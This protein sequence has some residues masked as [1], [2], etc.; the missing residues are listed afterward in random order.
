[1]RII[2]NYFLKEFL[3]NFLFSFLIITFF[4]ALGNLMIL[5]DMVI[6]KN[7]NIFSALQIFLYRMPYL[8]IY[9]LPLSFLLGV[10]LCVG[11]ISSDNEI[12]ALKVA[13][14]SFFKILSVFLMVGFIISLFSIVLNDYIIPQAHFAS[15][16]LEGKVGRDNPLAF[17][18]PGSFIEFN[19]YKLFAQDIE[20]NTLKNT[21]IYELKDGSSNVI[22]A[23]KGDFII[24]ED[25]LKIKLQNGF[26]EGPGMKYRIYF[27]NH[28]MHLPVEKQSTKVSKKP[29][30][31][32]IKELWKEINR[33]E[34]E[35]IDPLPLRVEFHR[36]I[37]LSF[38]S[39]VFALMGMGIAGAVRHREKT[40]NVGICILS[41]MVYY[42]L[43]ETVCKTLA[44]KMPLPVFLVMG[45]PN[46]IFLIIGGYFSYKLCVS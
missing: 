15:R 22:F 16:T 46:I 44:F 13:G 38:A 27:K 31:M 4:M 33:L 39:I 5:P 43:A 41:G 10:L 17:V 14:I 6:T 9:S 37:S 21:F 3:S 35:K 8:L 2:R 24:D 45:L 29:K 26:M 18:E 42:F 11:R 23:E 34:K 36:K 7:I 19:G 25:I 32:G 12:I 20:A 30:D 40:I 28:F 1:M